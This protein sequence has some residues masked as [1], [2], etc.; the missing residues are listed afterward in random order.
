MLAHAAPPR[1]RRANASLVAKR[2]QKS[3]I[4]NESQDPPLSL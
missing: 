4:V 2:E 1:E 3:A